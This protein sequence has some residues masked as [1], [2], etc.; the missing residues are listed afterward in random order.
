MEGFGEILPSLA[1]QQVCKLGDLETIRQQTYAGLYL[2]E[3]AAPLGSGDLDS[4]ARQFVET[5]DDPRYKHFTPSTKKKRLSRHSELKDWMPLYLGKA[6][7][8]GKRV[9]EH[10]H[11]S[12]EQ[13]TTALKLNARH[14]LKDASFRL[15]TLAVPVK[16]YDIILPIMEAGFRNMINPIV[17]R[18]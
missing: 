6:K 5:W 12:M 3:M 10:I 14:N 17:G 7:N 1:F 8:I 18:Q 9:W 15:S 4:W 13:P 11:L 16:N 2:I